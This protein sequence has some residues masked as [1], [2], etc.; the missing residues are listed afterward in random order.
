MIASGNC[1]SFLMRGAADAHVSILRA[2]FL[3]DPTPTLLLRLVSHWGLAGGASATKAGATAPLSIPDPARPQVHR[4][5][6]LALRDL[7]AG[8]PPHRRGSLA[9]VRRVRD[10]LELRPAESY[11]LCR[12]PRLAHAG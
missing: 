10:L 2:N 4:D 5:A 12:L 9:A 8:D 11:P 3:S 6:P 1:S 7:P